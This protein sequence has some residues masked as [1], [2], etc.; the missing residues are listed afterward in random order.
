[1]KKE[2]VGKNNS[3]GVVSVVFGI[4]SVLALGIGGIVLGIIGFFFGWNQKKNN[5]NK[6]SKWGI[7]LSAIGIV[8][9]IIVS[10]LLVNYLGNYLSQIQ[11]GA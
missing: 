11:G 7:W 4:M 3:S 5:P 8:L 1:M 10:I 2:I 6:W 9:G